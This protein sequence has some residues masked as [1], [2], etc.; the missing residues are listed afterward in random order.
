MSRSG[1]WLRRVAWL[2]V[3]A[4]IGLMVVTARAILEGERQMKQSDEAFHR[5]DVRNA[6]LHARR[7]A[8]LYAPGAPH[9]NLAYTRLIAVALGAEAAGDV[10]TARLA[11]RAVRGAALESAHLWVARHNELDRAN[12]SLA[13]LTS[14]ATANS[15]A[16]AAYERAL[17]QLQRD[18]GPHGTYLLLLAVG[19]GLSAA[20]LALIGAQGLGS[21]G[22]ISLVEA[23]WGLILTLIGAACWTIA[24]YRA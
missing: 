23:R 17:E 15:D 21:D 5:G 14:T 7:A 11:W 4:V 22:R 19:L 13:R 20:G 3:L 16:R 1:I 2:M 6:V 24:V 9:V 10:Q 12:K 8:I 18:Q